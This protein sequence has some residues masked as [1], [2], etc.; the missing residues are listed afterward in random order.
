MAARPEAHGRPLAASMRWHEP[1][2]RSCPRAPVTLK[3]DSA[4]GGLA[5]I[6]TRMS[7]REGGAGWPPG[8][9]GSSAS[10]SGRPQ[11]PSRSAHPRRRRGSSSRPRQRAA[12]PHQGIVGE[13]HMVHGGRQ[14]PLP[15]AEALMEHRRLSEVG[16]WTG[17]QS[18]TFKRRV[19]HTVE[20]ETEP[21][22]CGI[23]H[24]ILLPGRVPQ[25]DSQ[26]PAPA[27]SPSDTCPTTLVP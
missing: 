24:L 16:L 19:E 4:H 6:L 20:P 8:P 11:P 14:L 10:H 22:P 2:A 7:W 3:P 9:T 15:V 25:A 13:A 26:E 5:I 17:R 21:P 1:L 23:C 12:S 27:A 18:G